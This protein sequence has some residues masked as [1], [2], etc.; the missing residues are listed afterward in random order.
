[1]PYGNGTGPS[2][3]GSRTGRGFGFCSGFPYP[4][5]SVGPGFG[6][7]RGRGFGRG[8]GWRAGFRPGFGPFD[9][10][11][12]EPYDYSPDQEKDFLKHQI[13]AMEKTIENL[14]TRLDEVDKKE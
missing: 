5:Y 9:Y 14:K 2:G 11:F 12:P 10:S 8:F 4:G 3:M 1:M 13:S 6:G 7:G